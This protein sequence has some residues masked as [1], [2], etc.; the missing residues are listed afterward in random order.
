MLKRVLEAQYKVSLRT[1]RAICMNTSART[2]Q[3]EGLFHNMS[4]EISS[5]RHMLIE[6]QKYYKHN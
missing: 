5:I 2:V 6:L 4:A 3:E 1:T